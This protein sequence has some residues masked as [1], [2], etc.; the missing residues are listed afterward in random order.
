MVTAKV[1]W[2]GRMLRKPWYWC[3]RTTQRWFFVGRDYTLLVPYGQR[4]FTPWFS[5]DADPR[6]AEILRKVRASGRDAS[7]A[8]R[9]YMLYQ[10]SNR[11]LS[12]PGDMA[13]CGVFTGGTA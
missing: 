9:C 1:S 4:V 7:A 10:L 6:F 5:N 8:D 11:C 3:W 2:L 13:E 12:L